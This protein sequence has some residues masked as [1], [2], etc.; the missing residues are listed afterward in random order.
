M[1]RSAS[2]MYIKD[3]AV[4]MVQK[5]SSLVVSFSDVLNFPSTLICFEERKVIREAE[6]Y[7]I[8]FTIWHCV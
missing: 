2:S 4:G 1:G 5:N 6:I 8:P 7:F 3:L